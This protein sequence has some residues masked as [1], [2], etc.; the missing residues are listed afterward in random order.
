MNCPL[1]SAT[2]ADGAAECPSCGAIFAKLRERQ[3]KDKKKAEAALALAGSPAPTPP[4]NPW[5]LRIAAAVV[6]AA[7]MLGLGLYFRARMEKT[8]RLQ[9]PLS[10]D[11]PTTAKLRDPVTGKLVSVEVHLSPLSSSP[12]PPPR[13]AAEP[14]PPPPGGPAHDPDFDD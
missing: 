12:E 8:P 1:C 10:Y 6:V 3:E 2:A 5:T 13:P 4:L 14:E 9:K 7:W 11:A